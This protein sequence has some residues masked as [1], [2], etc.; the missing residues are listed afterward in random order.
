MNQEFTFQQA[1]LYQINDIS[2]WAKKLNTETYSILLE[3]VLER[4]S[5][6]YDSPYDVLRGG[7][8]AN[9]VANIYRN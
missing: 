6:G 7:G 9:I 1:F 2:D 4:N 8:L 3:K 5:K